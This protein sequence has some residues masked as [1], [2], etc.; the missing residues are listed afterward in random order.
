MQVVPAL[1]IG[2]FSYNQ[3]TG[4]Y[5][6]CIVCGAI[7]SSMYVV[8][9]YFGYL[10]HDMNNPLAIDSGITGVIIQFIVI[11]STEIIHRVFIKKGIV[12]TE[13]RISI[14]NQNE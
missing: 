11:Y 12:P 2:L 14:N 3:I 9:I 7:L 6:W 4:I 10:K 5:L 8:G 1:L 13:G